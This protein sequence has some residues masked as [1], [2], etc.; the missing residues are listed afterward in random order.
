M[1]FYV[2]RARVVSQKNFFCHN[3]AASQVVYNR[4]LKNNKWSEDYTEKGKSSVFSN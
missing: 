3:E 2:A 1:H 4:L